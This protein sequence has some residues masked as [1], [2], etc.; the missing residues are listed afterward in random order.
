MCSIFFAYKSHPKFKLIVAA[1]RDE[2]YER[3]TSK[4]GFWEDSPYILAG[5]DLKNNGTWLGVTTTGR[6]AAVTNYRDPFGETGNRSRG[7]L[8]S[9]YLKSEDSPENF[10]SKVEDNAKN[11]RGFNLLLG[12]SDSLFY[13]SNR[14]NDI[15]KL[16]SGVYGL[17]N[18]LLDSP[19]R[20]VEKGKEALKAL[21]V[22]NDVT[23]EN[24]F[25]FL[26]DQSRANDSELPDTGIGL[27]MERVLSPIFI[28]TP[29]YG[30]R[31]STV[32]LMGEN[33][34][35]DFAERTFTDGMFEGGEVN[36]KFEVEN[37][38]KR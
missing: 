18:H 2:F 25:S 28:I 35:I 23:K 38:I 4:A 9:E 36:F 31:S 33:K 14:R 8:L 5:R 24:L 3:P 10:L 26:A 32:V 34:D 21:L 6:F 7:L 11:Y 12:N 27:E 19:W 30:T 17:S 16:T 20:K 37:S 13:Y 22:T 29:N 1:N 15:K